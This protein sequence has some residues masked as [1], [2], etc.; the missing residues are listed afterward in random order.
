MIVEQ[1]LESVF[2]LPHATSIQGDR[3][4]HP[5]RISSCFKTVLSHSKSPRVYVTTGWFYFY[6][7]AL[8]INQR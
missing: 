2:I 6:M 8:N 7:L 3:N 5:I 1:A 4:V